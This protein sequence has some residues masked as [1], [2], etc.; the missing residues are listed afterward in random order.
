MMTWDKGKGKASDLSFDAHARQEELLFLPDEDEEDPFLESEDDD[1]SDYEAIND[2][3]DQDKTSS[4]MM[5]LDPAE[6][7]NLAKYSMQIPIGAAEDHILVDVNMDAQSELQTY[8]GPLS[9]LRTQDI[10]GIIEGIQVGIDAQKSEMK[11]KKY[12]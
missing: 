12:F 3:T 9:S 4:S 10:I 6:E 2:N 8:S 1:Q 7:L 11:P 5:W